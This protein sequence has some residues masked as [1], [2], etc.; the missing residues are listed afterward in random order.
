MWKNSVLSYLV[1]SVVQKTK[2]EVVKVL[3]ILF[4]NLYLDAQLGR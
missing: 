2:Y 1:N 4:C 3:S